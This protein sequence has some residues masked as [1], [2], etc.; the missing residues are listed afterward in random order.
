VTFPDNV[1][2]NYVSEDSTF[3]A[4]LRV[5]ERISELGTT[6]GPDS[7]HRQYN[8][9]FYS[10]YPNIPQVCDVIIDVQSKTDFK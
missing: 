5:A 8:A 9:Q 3:P 10:C 1:L 7:F 6:N 2:G 4:A